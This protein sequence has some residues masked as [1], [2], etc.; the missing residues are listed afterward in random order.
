MKLLVATGLYPPDIGGPATHTVFLE[1]HRE[2]L[3]LDLVVL[4]FAVVRQYPPVI[5]HIL[6]VVRI[7]RS[8]RGCDALYALDTMSVGV[9]LMI[10]SVLTRTRL[11]LRVPG[12]YAWEQG[13]Q[14]YGITET[15]DEFRTHTKHPFPVRIMSFLQ[16]MVAKRATHVIVPS[17]YMKEVVSGWGVPKEKITRVYS[18][19]KEISVH[20]DAIQ[21]TPPP[22]VITSAARLVPWKGMQVLID[23]VV[24]LH[25][26][27]L[28]VFLN[29]I[30]DGVCRT[31]LEAHVKTAD[32]TEYIR[33][34]GAQSREALGE[35]IFA[36]HVF[37]LNTSYEGF[38]HQLLEVMSLGVPV[39]TTPVGGNTELIADGKTGV[40]V[41][42]NDTNALRD[43]LRKLFID[44][45]LRETLATQAK[46][47][48]VAFKEERIVSELRTVF[49]SIC[50][51]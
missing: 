23:A 36:S 5:R 12:D 29:I 28:P 37:V 13:Q 27:G 48:L 22:F 46:A 39:I 16:R 34:H 26:E 31:D 42:Y 2:A 20:S 41:P 24:S 1:K 9:P 50:N 32:A 47:S 7:V 4:P 25:R 40:F 49:Q 3:G 15:L 11:I 14:R 43:A 51:S 6:Y 44:S 19:L 18:V 17:N 33:F 35:K 45:T 21:P 10:A 8:M 38:S 30:G